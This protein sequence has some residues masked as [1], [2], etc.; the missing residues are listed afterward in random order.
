[1]KT[2]RM[3]Q[4]LAVVALVLTAAFATTTLVNV[5]GEP[6]KSVVADRPSPADVKALFE[7]APLSASMRAALV[8]ADVAPAPQ[9]AEVAALFDVAPL[10][11]SMRARLISADA[12]LQQAEVAALF[13][14][15]PRS[16]PKSTEAG[17]TR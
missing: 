10:S 9:P 2:E 11:V 15:A 13:D 14:V 6:A 1:M 5:A 4:P 17:K 7:I 3:L 8:K 16:A 12:A